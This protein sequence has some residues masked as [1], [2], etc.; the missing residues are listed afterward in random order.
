[1]WLVAGRGFRAGG[2]LPVRLL[3]LTGRGVRAGR[4][5][6]PVGLS[7]LADLASLLLLL[8]LLGLCPF[9]PLRLHLLRSFLF[10]PRE[11][12]ARDAFIRRRLSLFPRGRLV[13]RRDQRMDSHMAVGCNLQN[14]TGIRHVGLV[15]R[16]REDRHQLAAGKEA[17]PR[18]HHLNLLYKK[19]REFEP[20][21][22]GR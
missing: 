17:E 1:M 22:L 11:T 6:L 4:R 7:L 3:L 9:L 10:L 18:H 12:A 13:Q 15:T 21:G 19:R 5:R 16:S 8:V 20:D 2:R 14:G